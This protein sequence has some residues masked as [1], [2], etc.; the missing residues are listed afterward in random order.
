MTPAPRCEA[1]GSPLAADQ[2]YCLACGTRAG[3]RS[4]QLDALLG[5]IR[6]RRLPGPAG[7]GVGAGAAE[8][9]RAAPR[10]LPRLPG[11]WVSAALVAL[12]VGF[13]A[14]LGDT[15]AG[16]SGAGTA[17]PAL[18]LI[19][20]AHPSSPASATTPGPTPPAAEA[21]ETPAPAETTQPAEPASHGGSGAADSSPSSPA[22]PSPAPVAPAEAHGGSGHAAPAAKLSDVK[23]VFLIV[24]DDEPYALDFGPEAKAAYLTRTLEPKGELLIR[25]D[26][27]AHE[28]LPNAI[29]LV[30]GQ[31]PTAQTAADCPD[32]TALTPGDSGPDE[33]ALGEGCVYPASVKTLPGQLEA[34]HLSWRA[35]LQGLEEG[36]AAPAACAHPSLGAPDPTFSTGAYAGYR[37]PFVYF[38]SITANPQCAADVV[39]IGRLSHDLAGAART[40]PAFSYIV[41][42]RCEDGGPA[43][44]APG[45]PT[46]P[47]DTTPFLE[48]VVPEIISSKAYRAGGLIVI[49]TDEAPSS[50]EYADSSSCCGQPPYPN[51]TTGGLQHGGGAVGALLISPFV[52]GGTTLPAEYDH[53]SLLKTIEQIF[54]LGNIG[55][56]KLPA[57]Q[58]LAASVLDKPPAR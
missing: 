15:G 7:D 25:Y 51:L 54:G 17:A 47:A 32:Y 57:I 10:T 3:G 31:G 38:A 44:C 6:E 35:Y 52:K 33:Q 11:P 8:P 19:V 5:R 21:Q 46:G 48:K 55:Y 56:A 58:P 43:A 41:P 24:L 23:H 20:P 50:G 53:Y 28:Q 34:H 42:G 1:C 40:V 22:P 49:T 16:A 45:A 9:R 13:G 29:A 26:A 27:V 12:F 37:D 14:L 4:A 39:G 2:R 36:S 18:K 30:S